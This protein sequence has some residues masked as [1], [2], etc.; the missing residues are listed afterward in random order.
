VQGL[1]SSEL[2]TEFGQLVLAGT[3]S[4][5]NYAL[6]ATSFWLIYATT[7]TFHVAHAVAYMIAGY[8]TI[9]VC[10]WAKLPLWEGALGAILTAAL[11]GIVVEAFVYRPLR[12]RGAS[13]MGIFLASLGVATA[14]PNVIQLVFGPEVFQAPDVPNRT[15]SFGTITVTSLHLFM[16]A[17]AL[18]L[19]LAVNQFL[20]KS[21]IG[22]A[23][24]AVRTNPVLAMSVGIS[25][26]R[27]FLFVFGLGS[28]L[29]GVAGYF[30]TLDSAASSTMG[31]Q[32]MLYGLIGVFL[33]GV[34][35]IRGAG[36]GGFI[37]GF[38]LVFT[39]LFL[40]QDLGII[41]VFVILAAILIFRPEGLLKGDATR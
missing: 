14:G 15:L 19:I 32:P 2:L 4:G 29:V 40:S 31:L 23:I 13:I 9:V 21:K 5:I 18:V 11:F 1:I 12:A 20:E 35:S 38:L 26:D 25:I 8:A 28:L 41:F 36:L 24:S 3:I 6:I 27:V 39:G 10:T 33:G 22:N 17:V 16:A 30:A 34:A 37:L 7:G